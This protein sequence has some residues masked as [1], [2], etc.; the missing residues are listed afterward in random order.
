MSNFK[1]LLP[2]SETITLTGQAIDKLINAGDGDATLLY[3]CILK[4]R[5][6]ST[7]QEF[8][9]VLGK[10]TEGIIASMSVL[11]RLGL[12]RLDA[13][14]EKEADDSKSDIQAVKA[15]V[16]LIRSESGLKTDH[17]EKRNLEPPK[18]TIEDIKAEMGSSSIFGAL[19]EEVQR[20]LGKILSQDELQRLFGIYEDLSLEP[21]VILQLVTHCISESRARSGGRMPSIRY[22]E[23]AAYTWEREGVFSLDCAEKYLKALENRR[24]ARGEIKRSLQ[25]LS[26]EL[27]ETETS[28]VDNWIEMGFGADAVAI[29]YDRMMVQTGKFVWRYIDKIMTSWHAKCLHSPQE[30]MEKD[31]MSDRGI[32]M[33]R[34]KT[35]GEKFGAA[36]QAEVDR[37]QRLLDKLKED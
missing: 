17:V 32:A 28:Y 3:L 7:V 10:S 19:V 27:S 5:G 9:S 16:A 12:V 21:E 24:S 23:K 33:P 30:I 37:M 11:S 8:A 35:Y 13:E 2:G 31:R 15:D 18:R 34:A 29:A 6:Y 20:S 26:R 14:P 1:Y 36:N 4:T 22:I 25:L